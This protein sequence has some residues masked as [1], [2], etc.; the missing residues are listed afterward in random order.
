M[1]GPH[2]VHEDVKDEFLEKLL[3]VIKEFY[4]ENPK[5]SKDFGRIISPNHVKRL[6][7]YLEDIQGREEEGIKILNDKGGEVDES[8]KY[9]SPTL[10][11]MEGDWVK[12]GNGF[13][14]PSGLVLDF[15]LLLIVDGL[16]DGWFI[17]TQAGVVPSI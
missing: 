1:P 16:T 14:S 3:G 11:L 4:G 13:L 9:V 17:A 6:A 10:V 7:S 8:E 5:E 15:S 12:K 2:Q